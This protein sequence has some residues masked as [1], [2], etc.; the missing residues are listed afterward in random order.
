[1]EQAMIELVQ[2]IKQ[3]AEAGV[4]Q[5]PAL[6]EQYI[7]YRVW[8]FSIWIGMV[9]VFIL[10]SI[11]FLRPTLERSRDARMDGP[12]MA[13]TIGLIVWAVLTFFSVLS[14]ASSIRGIVHAKM[15]SATFVY[16]E[17]ILDTRESK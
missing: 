15:S 8:W 16:K 14:V 12:A 10:V 3:G 17:L 9:V 2:L 7:G 11:P 4:A 5:F 13:C 6:A 1:M